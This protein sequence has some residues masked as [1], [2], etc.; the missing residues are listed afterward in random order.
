M[1]GRHGNG[2]RKLRDDLGLL[3]AIDLLIQLLEIRFRLVRR[4]DLLGAFEVLLQAVRNV[5]LAVDEKLPLRILA[6]P[7][8]GDDEQGDGK[9]P[10]GG[11]GHLPVEEQKHDRDQYGRRAGSEQKGHDMGEHALLISA[12]LHDGGG[13]VRE[14]APSEKGKGQSA[15]HLGKLDPLSGTLAVHDIVGEMVFEPLGQQHEQEYDDDGCKIA[16][17]SREGL[18]GVEQMIQVVVGRHAQHANGCHHDEVGESAEERASLELESTPLGQSELLTQHRWHPLRFSKRLISD[19]P[20]TSGD[21]LPCFRQDPRGIPIPRW[22]RSPRR[23]SCPRPPRSI[24][25]V[26]S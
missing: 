12:V 17:K 3:R 7:R 16:T 20:P 13:E 14:V 21:T 19:S 6:L 5:K 4:R 11:D 18:R 9:N 25:G 10:E 26:Q 8:E 1:R 2:T 22:P 15:Q 23:R 24:A